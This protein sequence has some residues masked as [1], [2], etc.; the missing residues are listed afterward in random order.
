[1][2]TN[3]QTHILTTRRA[4]SGGRLAAW[5]LTGL[6]AL[7]AASALNVLARHLQDFYQSSKLY[8]EQGRNVH[9]P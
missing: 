7:P 9:L 8:K 5:L 4:A 6:L 3:P 1:M 2:K